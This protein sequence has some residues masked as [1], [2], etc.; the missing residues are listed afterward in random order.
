L[1]AFDNE[2]CAALLFLFNFIYVNLI[3]NFSLAR[4]E[5]E[6]KNFI[7]NFISHVCKNLKHK[8]VGKCSI[9]TYIMPQFKLYPSYAK[10]QS[11]KINFES[12]LFE[13]AARES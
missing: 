10:R 5:L 13:C 11:E 3:G 12:F 6:L 7:K 2:K 1:K 9:I 8:A 4:D